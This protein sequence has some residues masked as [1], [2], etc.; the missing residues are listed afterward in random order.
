MALIVGRIYLR[1]LK[2]LAAR[3]SSESESESSRK[4]GETIFFAISSDEGPRTRLSE[5]KI[6]PACLKYFSEDEHH[7]GPRGC[8]KNRVS[9]LKFARILRYTTQAR[10]QGGLL[11][12]PD[13]AMLMGIGIDAIRR[14]IKSNAKIVV[15]TRGLIKDMGRSVRCPFGKCAYGL[16]KF[17]LGYLLP[18]IHEISPGYP[19]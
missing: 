3:L 8:H 6:V 1:R 14:L 5:G 12:I 18:R 7:L 16:K 2:E 13:L 19:I 17:F 9:D 4:V 11:S 15:P 10:K